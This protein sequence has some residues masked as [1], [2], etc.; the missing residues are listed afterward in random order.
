MKTACTKN[1]S[2]RVCN[3]VFRHLLAFSLIAV[4]GTNANSQDCT[5]ALQLQQDPI[6]RSDYETVIA[7]HQSTQANQSVEE[8]YN[9]IQSISYSSD[10]PLQSAHSGDRILDPISMECI[11]CHDGT[12][13]RAVY[14]KV[15][16]PAEAAVGSSL[17]V[18][19]SHPVGMDYTKYVNN[20]SYVA[21]YSLPQN[22]VL[23]DGKVACISCHDMLNKTPAYLAV[24]LNSSN[25]CFSCHRK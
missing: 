10:I 13:A 12:V 6:I 3:L 2:S 18:G 22:M 21:Y 14:Y 23:M 19:G 5:L 4:A 15:K 9:N 8:M 7:A 17:T 1:P 20:R 25:L 24:D 11:T 16:T